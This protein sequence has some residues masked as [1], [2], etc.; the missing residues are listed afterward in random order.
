MSG[1]FDQSDPRSAEEGSLADLGAEFF[2]Q[3][4]RIEVRISQ[5]AADAA[6]AAWVR[7]DDAD[8]DLAAAPEERR[9]RYRAGTLALIGLAIEERGR[10]DGD[11]VVVELDA[12]EVGA[13]LEAADELGRL[14]QRSRR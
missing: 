3:A 5:A 7:D 13:A 8:V 6:R 10:A 12:W 11:D 2:T 14:N 9:T 4:T 1:Q